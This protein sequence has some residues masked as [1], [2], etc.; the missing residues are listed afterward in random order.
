MPIQQVNPP[1]NLPSGGTI[2][3]IYPKQNLNYNQDYQ[4]PIVSNDVVPPQPVNNPNLAEPQNISIYYCFG[5]QR[6]SDLFCVVCDD[7]THIFCEICYQLSQSYCP[8]CR[9][10]VCCY[11]NIFDFVSNMNQQEGYFFHPTC[12]NAASQNS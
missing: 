9:S 12:M 3:N 8:M 2:Q 4:Q 7:Q 10:I 1:V 5:C 6:P 11:C